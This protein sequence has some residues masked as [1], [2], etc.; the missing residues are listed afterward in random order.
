[1]KTAQFPY[2]QWALNYLASHANSVSCHK[3]E[4][5]VIVEIIEDYIEQA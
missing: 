5:P 4:D 1:M 2:E 3:Y